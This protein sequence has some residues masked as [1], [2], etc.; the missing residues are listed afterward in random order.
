MAFDDFAKQIFKDQFGDAVETEVNGGTLE[1]SFDILLLGSLPA[2]QS[3]DLLPDL[4]KQYENNIIEYKS[5]RDTYNMRQ[6]LK[7]NGDF[8]YYSIINVST[9]IMHSLT[10][11][12]GLLLLIE[13][14]SID[15]MRKMDF[16][17]NLVN[18]AIIFYQIV[19]L[20]FE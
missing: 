3:S 20:P 19:I 6:V 11:V 5:A 9:W 18:R 17:R 8:S 4:F 2:I 7:L 12:Y 15:N 16:F 10:P 13:S 14:L 1:K